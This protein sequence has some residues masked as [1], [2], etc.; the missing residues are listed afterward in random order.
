ML[1]TE[2]KEIRNKLKLFWNNFEI[3]SR[4]AAEKNAANGKNYS[5][6]YYAKCSE[7]VA[8]Y[9]VFP[10]LTNYKIIAHFTKDKKS[11][12]YPSG[13][14]VKDFRFILLYA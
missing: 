9:S 6:Q 12:L 10:E 11:K 14:E 1:Y 5:W 4:K 2:A 8:N 13:D 3:I 7:S